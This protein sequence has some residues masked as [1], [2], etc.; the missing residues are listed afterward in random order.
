MTPFLINTQQILVSNNSLSVRNL[1]SKL[2]NPY[3]IRW[4]KPFNSA[5][6]F[7]DSFDGR[8]FRA[9]Y[10]LTLADQKILL[11]S[12]G[13]YFKVEWP[14]SSFPRGPEDF[15]HTKVKKLLKELLDI[16]SLTKILTVKVTANPFLILNADLKTI[17]RCHLLYCKSTYPQTGDA[18]KSIFMFNPL[19]G[20]EADVKQ[21]QKNL[22]SSTSYFDFSDALF[23]EYEIDLKNYSKPFYSLEGKKN[24][25][26]AIYEILYKN[27]LILQKNE[28]GII[29]DI[30][31]EFLHDYRV[32]CRRMR[33]VL[34]LIKTVIDL[35]V[36][37]MLQLDLKH[38]G[39]Y[40]GP[41]RDLDVYLRREEEYKAL[42]PKNWSQKEIHTIFI[43]LKKQRRQ[44]YQNMLKMLK[45]AEYNE[46]VNRWKDFFANFDSHIIKDGSLLLTTSALILK[47]FKRI[48]KEGEMLTAVDPDDKFHSLR[49]SCKKLRYLLEFFGPLYPQLLVNKAVKQLKKLQDNL[50]E[51]NDY[52]VQIDTLNQLLDSSGSK[53]SEFIKTVAGLISVLDYKMHQ[54]RDEFY[55]LFADFSSQEN[56]K[57]Y[58]KLFG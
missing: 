22:P 35:P 30:D 13:E 12:K 29:N 33:S 6:S 48:I 42:L 37:Q 27:F 2:I 52:S 25:S 53:K 36:N 56:I 46:V 17:A 51:F 20:Y 54:L 26:Q 43:R 38:I 55:T 15:R 19:R 14:M 31:I 49:I 32:A 5:V 16:R 50:G 34:S 57:L 18:V 4:H 3:S 40:S 58:N 10:V 45:S 1:S 8:L 28:K 44:A 47:W 24:I 9:G 41:L 39:I 11:K 23:K 7:L 21:F